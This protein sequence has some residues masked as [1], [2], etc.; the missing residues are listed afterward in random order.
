M[1]E[2]PRIFIVSDSIG[3]TAQYVVDATVSQFNGYL[4]SKRF[5]YVQTTRELNNIIKKATEQKTLIAYT[6]IDP[7]LREE[8]ATLARK[9]NIYAVDIMG[10]MMEAF[11]EFFQKKPRLQPG[12]V[13]RL[14][15]DYFKRVEAM[16]FTVKYDDSNDDRGV[17]EADVVLIGVSRTSKTPMCIYLSY[18][19]YKAANIPLVPEVEPTPL[20]YENPDNKVIGLTIDPLLLNEI[21]QERLKS[22]GIDPESSYA[23]IDRIN[24]ELE[25]AEKT[26]E[27]IG[28]PVIDV[29]NKSIEESANEVIDYLNG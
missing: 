20:I 15:K 10:P 24:V 6:L 16:E 14:D 3:E 25:Y 29:T 5:S 12:L 4:D 27:K 17:K 13:H 9:N 1:T 7:R 26:M 18:R 8:I 21:R 23:S 22:L 2:K 11:E 19:G 28:C